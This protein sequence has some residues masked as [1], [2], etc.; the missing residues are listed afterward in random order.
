MT[1]S[2]LLH[3]HINVIGAFATF[4]TFKK[5][6]TKLI[7]RAESF[8]SFIGSFV[9]QNFQHQLGAKH[10]VYYSTMRLGRALKDRCVKSDPERD[11]M[12]TMLEDL[13]NKWSVIRSIVS[14]RSVKF[15]FSLF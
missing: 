7:S 14:Q 1:Y 10:P 8:C 4:I 3:V 9:F 12:N 6:I 13:K 11:V 5:Q 2:L 15:H